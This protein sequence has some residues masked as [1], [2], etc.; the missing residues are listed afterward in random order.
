[1]S[2]AGSVEAIEASARRAVDEG[3]PDARRP[4]DDVKGGQDRAAAC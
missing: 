2:F 4:V 1:M 3:D